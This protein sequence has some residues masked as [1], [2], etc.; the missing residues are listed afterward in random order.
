M[1]V[2]EYFSLDV[3]QLQNKH[4]KKCKTRTKIYDKLLE[5]CFYR[6]NA[7]SENDDSFCLYSIPEFI[8]GMP[9]YN[10][11]YCAAYIIYNLKN[12]GFIAQFFNP[13]VI[14]VSWKYDIPNYIKD[15]TKKVITIT[16]STS[17]TSNTSNT[18]KYITLTPNTHTTTSKQFRSIK[19]YKPSGKFIF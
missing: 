18:S 8:L 4:Q 19:D 11:A 14:F 12:K 1:N 2:D 10:L 5:K 17:N 13:N 6:I 7:A 16:P 9:L 3:N 15:N